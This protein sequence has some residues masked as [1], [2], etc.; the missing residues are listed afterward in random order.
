MDFSIEWNGNK[1]SCMTSLDVLHRFLFNNGAQ[2]EQPWN[3]A[4]AMVLFGS[5]TSRRPSRSMRW[6][7]GWAEKPMNVNG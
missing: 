1:V 7:S 2:F 6:V 5:L 3:D 4:Q